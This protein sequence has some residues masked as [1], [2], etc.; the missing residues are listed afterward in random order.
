MSAVKVN[1]ECKM[2]AKWIWIN[3]IKFIY[4]AGAMVKLS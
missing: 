1:Y 4:K 3:E 2:G